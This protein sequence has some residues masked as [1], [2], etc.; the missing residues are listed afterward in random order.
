[1][2][3]ETTT[4]GYPTVWT[5]YWNLIWI[6]RINWALT[7]VS[8][9]SL[10]RERQMSAPVECGRGKWPGRASVRRGKYPGTNV[11]YVGHRNDDS[12]A[13][14]V[15]S[16]FTD[17]RIKNNT[18]RAR[19]KQYTHRHHICA[20]HLQ[21]KSVTTIHGLRTPCRARCEKQQKSPVI[22]GLDYVKF[23]FHE[24]W[25]NCP[26]PYR[27]VSVE[28]K[29]HEQPPENIPRIWPSGFAGGM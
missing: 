2:L 18:R 11:L 6:Y 25:N 3:T 28:R 21:H 8:S 12:S 4:I 1:M 16:D 9:F 7:F 14:A 10:R 23:S 13:L 24:K 26:H 22:F 19:H 15:V 5:R 20:R 29:K 17:A 27:M